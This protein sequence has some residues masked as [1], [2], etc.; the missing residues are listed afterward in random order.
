MTT[1]NQ[2]QPNNSI[3]GNTPM[4]EHFQEAMHLWQSLAE[5]EGVTAHHYFQTYQQ[6]QQYP[7]EEQEKQLYGVV[8]EIGKPQG[9]YDLLAVYNNHWAT[10]HP[11]QGIKKVWLRPDENFDA[12]ITEVLE[13]GKI[14]L[15]NMPSWDADF[16][17]QVAK[18]WMRVHLLTS[19]GMYSAEA[20][21]TEMA[22]SPLGQ[23]MAEASKRLMNW[24]M[25]FDPKE[26]EPVIR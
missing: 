9:I 16:E 15:P 7:N 12:L 3:T 21:L 4:N 25:V 23:E 11:H 2:Q 22:H 5:Q 8:I 13:S 10:L 19:Q 18:G 6:L 14:L 17:Q 24:L 20:P 1:T 26:H